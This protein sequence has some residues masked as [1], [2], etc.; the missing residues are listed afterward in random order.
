[1]KL[2][3]LNPFVRNALH[4]LYKPKGHPVYIADFHIIYIDS[5]EI[6]IRCGGKDIRLPKGSLIHLPSGSVYELYLPKGHES[7]YPL[8]AVV[9]FDL[10][11]CDNTHTKI[12][13]PIEATEG[14]QYGKTTEDTELSD[15][16]ED[17]SFLSE[18]HVFENAQSFRYLMLKLIE[19]FRNEHYLYRELCSCTM[20][21]ILIRL[22]REANTKK[23]DATALTNELKSY[24]EANFST[25]I[26][27]ESLA[28]RYGYHVN[29]LERLFRQSTGT[30]IRQYVISLRL[31]EAKRLLSETSMPISDIAKTV[32]FGNYSY[33]SDYFRNNVGMSPAEFRKQLQNTV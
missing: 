30:T 21:E 20:K 19:E 3:K 8:L 28:G 4:F 5:G 10:T 33:F 24:L 29:S 9:D 2:W 13:Y 15:I 14:M 7:D 16:A 32:G 18:V 23:I 11:Q 27:N 12:K 22:H 6:Y 26:D 1:M 17:D 25:P 31:A